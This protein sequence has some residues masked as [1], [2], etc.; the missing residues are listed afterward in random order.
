ME[1]VGLQ[2]QELGT[3]LQDD[4]QPKKVKDREKATENVVLD[5]DQSIPSVRPDPLSSLGF[6]LL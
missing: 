1:S 4:E 5:G 3:Q 6:S 2:F